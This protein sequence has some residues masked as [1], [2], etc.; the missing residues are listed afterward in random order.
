MD[1]RVDQDEFGA[2]ENEVTFS[3]VPLED[4]ASHDTMALTGVAAL[5][6]RR[7]D[8]PVW[9]I[10]GV[11]FLSG[12]VGVVQPLA[13]RMSSTHPKLFAAVV[14][15]AVYHWSQ[16]L[17]TAFGLMLIYLSWNLYRRKRM[18][19]VLAFGITAMSV[20]VH[21]AR[22]GTERLA[23]IADLDLMH[24]V[25]VATIIP[26]VVALACLW[27]WRQKFTVRSEGRSMKRAAVVVALSAVVAVLYGTVG[28]WF[29]D[30]RDFGVNFM[31][32][33]AFARTIR[34]FTF[35]GNPDLVARTK[36]GAW[37]LESLHLFG[38]LAAA[39]A[40]H[41]VFRPLEYHLVTLP[42]EH[43]LAKKSLDAFG[44]C[45]LD[46]YKLLDD[47]SY[48][49]STD[50]PSFVAYKVARNVAVALSDPTGPVEHL[51]E[52]TSNF[53]RQCHNNGWS[54][55]FLQVTPLFL[56]MYKGLGFK[57]LKIGEDGIVDIDKFCATTISKKSF[58]APIKKLEKQ[59]L[60]LDRMAPPHSEALL[61]EVQAVSDSWLSLPGRRERSF[62]LGQFNR[63]VLQEHPLYVLRQADNKIIAFVDQVPSYKKGEATIDM[64]RHIVDVP[65]GS[66]D[67]LFA[68]LI[69]S[70]Q[71]QGFKY[72]SLGL[73]ALSGVGEGED[74]SLEEKAIK[75]IYN[76]L[77][78][79]F[80]YKGLRRYKEKFEPEWED[81]YL[82]YEGGPP[83]LIRT[84]LALIKATE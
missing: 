32:S 79:F 80:S 34:E 14:P 31:W 61:N 7:F 12:L 37:F 74:P 20:L 76:H 27:I 82:I 28:F 65:S 26:S 73:A 48:F 19:W 71:S 38:I 75:L 59:G 46:D 68:K 51:G 36:Y 58:K 18:A 66:M 53:R 63:R 5:E 6:V 22:I 42:R 8:W 43:A 16:S 40:A 49:F 45:A 83:G 25:P 35:Q 69:V 52:I 78:R 41:S 77:N 33:D 54:V 50:G 39:F 1:D 70:L 84:A 21:G 44:T 17:T 67:F 29:L 2:E 15:Y 47:K 9:L 72:F 30:Q 4:S 10:A 60:H 64:M 13:V 56:T 62:S 81:R 57:V 11:T 3:G 23:L 24:S 55:A